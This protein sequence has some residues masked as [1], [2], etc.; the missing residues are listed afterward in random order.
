MLLLLLLLLQFLSWD[1]QLQLLPVNMLVTFPCV[2]SVNT[3]I[4]LVLAEN[5][6]APAVVKKGTRFDSAE[7]LLNQPINHR[8]QVLVKPATTVEKLGISKG[9]VPRSQLLITLEGF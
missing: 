3:I 6:L 2:T 9:T 8:E 7:H 5:C 4:I 1:P